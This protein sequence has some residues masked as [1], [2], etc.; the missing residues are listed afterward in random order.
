[1][2]LFFNSILNMTLIKSISLFDY[3]TIENLCCIFFILFG[4]NSVEYPGVIIPILSFHCE[5]MV[6]LDTWK[7][8]SIDSRNKSFGWL[9]VQLTALVVKNIATSIAR[10][11][12]FKKLGLLQLQLAALADRCKILAASIA[13]FACCEKFGFDIARSARCQKFGCGWSFTIHPAIVQPW[14]MRTYVRTC[15]RI[16][17][18]TCVRTQTHSKVNWEQALN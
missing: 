9:Q 16:H 5:A 2:E 17:V 11:T 4:S 10:F 8:I 1:M 13:T 3:S 7:F 14:C 6:W 15:V 12:R 18:R